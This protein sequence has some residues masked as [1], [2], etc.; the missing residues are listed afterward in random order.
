MSSIKN[1]HKIILRKKMKGL[2]NMEIA[3]FDCD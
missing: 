2:Q 1:V 3:F